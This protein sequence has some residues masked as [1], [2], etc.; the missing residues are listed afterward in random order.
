MNRY[1]CFIFIFQNDAKVGDLVWEC[2]GSYADLTADDLVSASG[3]VGNDVL[4]YADAPEDYKAF[5]DA[6][7]AVMI[8]GESDADTDLASATEFMYL[9]KLGEVLDF[10]L[11]ANRNLV[12]EDKV[13]TVNQEGIDSLLKLVENC[14]K[15][16]LISDEW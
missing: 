13:Y 2:F 8:T 7:T 3:V 15:K 14:G 1:E 11:D 6:A 10:Y 12:V 9:T 16:Q 4:A 5:F